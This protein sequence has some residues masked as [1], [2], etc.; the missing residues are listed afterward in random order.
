MSPDTCHYSDLSDHGPIEFS[1]APKIAKPVGDRALPKH[2]L[3]HPSFA[4]RLKLLTEEVKFNANHEYAPLERHRLYKLCIKSAALHARDVLHHTGPTDKE[5]HRLVLESMA[6]CI[7]RNDLR[8]A[9]TLLQVSSNARSHVHI[10]NGRV[11]PLTLILLNN[12]TLTRNGIIMNDVSP[13]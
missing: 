7:W 1:F 8:T 5:H 10:A 11:L 12:Y 2:W 13:N 6:R 4:P 3:T 9:R